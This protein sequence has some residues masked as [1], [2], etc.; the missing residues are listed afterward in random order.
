MHNSLLS[1][2]DPFAD[3]AKKLTVMASN[4]DLSSREVESYTA[5]M[6]EQASKDE[7]T[8]VIKHLLN[9]IRMHK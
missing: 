9:H 6:V 2:K 5:K 8:V 3:W 1:V 4:N 7:L